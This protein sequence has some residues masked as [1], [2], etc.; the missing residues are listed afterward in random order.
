M[1]PEEEAMQILMTFAGNG[2][3]AISDSGGKDS[4]VLKRIAEKCREK[5]N[6]SYKIVHSHTG[7]DAPETVYFVRRERERA[8]RSGI[9]Y[10]ISYPDKTF[11]KLCLE[12]GMLPT[13]IAR[14]CCQELKENYNG[15]PGERIVTGVRKNESA[16]R[17]NNQGA[18]TIF[19]GKNQKELDN[20]PN[21]LNTP[22]GGHIVLNYDNDDARRTVEKCFRTNKTLINPLINWTDDDVWKYIREEKIPINPLYECGFNRVGCV[23]CPMASFNGRTQQF[24]RYPKYKERFIQIADR[25]VKTRNEKGLTK[26]QTVK[27]ETGLDYFRHWMEDPNVKGQFSFD[28]DGNITEDYT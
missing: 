25:I 6:L 20:D 2:T 13:R 15:A 11:G 8:I 3:A 7:L 27:M 24:A 21:V 19:K 14:F 5:Y 17:K 18:V 10:N 16:N 1:T 12:R 23:G 9:E 22:K 28:M 26:N 4:S